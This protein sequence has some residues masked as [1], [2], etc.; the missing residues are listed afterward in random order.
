MNY[1]LENEIM[2]EYLNL[3]KLKNIP[4][5]PLEGKLDL[6]YR[7]NNNCRHCWLRIPANSG[8]KQRELSLEEIKNMVDEARNMGC[9]RWSIS[10][11]EPMLRPDFVEIFNYITS[12]SASYSINTNGTLITPEIAHLLKRKGTKMVALYGATTDV[13]DHITR[14]PGSFEAV[15]RGFARLKEAGAGFIVQL[16]PMRDNYHQFDDMIKL[17]ES[18]SKHYRVGAPWLYLSDCGH[19]ERNQ[20]ITRQRL[21]PKDVIELDKPDPSYEECMNNIE[22]K[23]TREYD[24]REGEDR[25]F[26]SCIDRRRDFHIDPCGQMTFCGFI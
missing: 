1:P 5:L 21:E 10:G 15:M 25:L 19:Q 4:R 24:C 2:S 13:Y 11:G 22:K 8:E 20:E 17:A 12:K 6:T 18:L 14:V 16:I 3:K 9:R 7:C 23:E 26:A